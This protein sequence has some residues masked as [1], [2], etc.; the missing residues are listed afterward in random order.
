MSV[1]ATSQARVNPSAIANTVVQPPAIKVLNAA[2]AKRGS[3]NSP[4]KLPTDT[5]PSTNTLRIT[6]ARNG[7]AI[8]NT[9]A[10]TPN[11]GKPTCNHR[12]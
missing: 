11:K 5:P 10:D 2:A 4:T 8:S 1:R 6:V 12:P 9:P 3:V 7:P